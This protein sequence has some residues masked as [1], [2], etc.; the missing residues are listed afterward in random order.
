MVEHIENGV[1][2]ATKTIIDNVKFVSLT[3][4]EF[5]PRPYPRWNLIINVICLSYSYILIHLQM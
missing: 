2:K 5:Q 4:D 3:C 1:K